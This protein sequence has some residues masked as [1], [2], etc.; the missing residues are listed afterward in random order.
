[1]REGFIKAKHKKRIK[2]ET[3]AG[4]LFALPAI[5]GFLIFTLGPML[6][7]LVLSF[8][9][10]AIVNKI[11]FIGLKNY[12][13]LFNGQDPF[14][15]KSLRVT[16]TYVILSVPIGICFH[17]ISA[18]LMNRNIKGKSIFRVIYYIPSI[19]PIAA[20]CIIWL[21]MFNPDRGLVNYVLRAFHLPTSQWVGS[22]I[23]VV[24]SIVIIAIWIA[25][26]TMVVFLAGLQEIS[27]SL[28]EAIEIDG[29]NA[30]HKLIYVTIPMSTP[31]FFFNSLM[32]IISG[33]QV[34]IQPLIMTDGGPNNESLFY[35]LYLFREGFKF[36]RMGSASAMA[37]VMFILIL[38][39]TAIFYGLSKK[40]VY[41]GG[42]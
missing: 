18:V 8:T 3:L 37:W 16:F 32:G 42:E 36:S 23:A 30:F 35:A 10:Y 20:S 28:Y 11:N 4:I 17:F 19:I 31:I 40:W 5:L 26:N 24:P 29:G 15:Y 6:A 9:D 39:L 21:W 27:K 1:M 2:G 13:N 38:M 14:F 33:F 7:S 25:G 22:E 41:Y 12:I 34:F